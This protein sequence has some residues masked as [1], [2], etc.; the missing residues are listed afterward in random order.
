M[1]NTNTLRLCGGTF[2]VLLLREKRNN[3]TKKQLKNFG[4]DGLT[5]ISLMEHLILLFDDTFEKPAGDSM[6]NRTSLYKKCKISEA[7]CLPFHDDALVH[8]FD[9]KIKNNYVTCLSSMGEIADFFL[10]TEKEDKMC[11][12]VY[13]IFTVIKY[14]TH[15]KPEDCFYVTPD[16]IGVNKTNLLQMKAV[17]LPALLLGVWHYILMHC[18][19]NTVGAST[20][21]EWH[22][23]PLQKGD[24][25]KFTSSIGSSFDHEIKI[26]TAYETIDGAEKVVIEEDQEKTQAVTVEAEIL[27][28]QPLPAQTVNQTIQNQFNFYQTGNGIN[29]GHADKVEIKDGKVVNLK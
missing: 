12:L 11:E 13:S 7:D 17:N 23:A 14:D 19:D 10:A 25:H 28:E 8:A 9:R 26:S 22:T 1:I 27:Q 29:I 20:I 3:R 6:D 21:V 18:Q 4:S 24:R 2:F 16:G 15:I 5:N